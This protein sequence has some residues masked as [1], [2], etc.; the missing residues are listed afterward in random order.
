M[1]HV[2]SVSC[3]PRELLLS[4]ASYEVRLER[5]QAVEKSYKQAGIWYKSRPFSRVFSKV[6]CTAAHKKKLY[7]ALSQRLWEEFRFSPPREIDRRGFPPAEWRF[8]LVHRSNEDPV[9]TIYRSPEARI[10]AERFRARHTTAG[11]PTLKNDEHNS[12]RR[13]QRPNNATS[14]M[15]RNDPGFQHTNAHRRGDDADH[16]DRR[17]RTA[18]HVYEKFMEDSQDTLVPS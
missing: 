9:P 14:S 3:S 7:P 2:H 5:L 15:E 1:R 4:V 18:Q 16:T 6:G 10:R 8:C 11:P 13:R 17:E 12:R